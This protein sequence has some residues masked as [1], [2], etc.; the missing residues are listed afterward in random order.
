MVGEGD[1][2]DEGEEDDADKDGEEELSVLFRDW[3]IVEHES[4]IAWSSRECY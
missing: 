2:K 1:D 4:S 3:F